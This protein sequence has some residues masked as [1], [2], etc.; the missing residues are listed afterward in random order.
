VT[1]FFATVFA[2]LS[3]L[4]FLATLETYFFFAAVFD[5]LEEAF[6][7]DLEGCTAIATPVAIV[8]ATKNWKK[9]F[10]SWC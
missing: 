10:T 9:P 7:A 2:L 3:L 5:V 8:S 4:G 1:I 6:F